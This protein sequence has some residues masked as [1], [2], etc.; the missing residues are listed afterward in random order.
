MCGIA[1]IVSGI[2]IDLSPSTLF[3]SPNPEPL[4]TVSV[5]DL[6]AALRRRGPDSLGSKKVILQYNKNLNSVEDRELVCEVIEDAEIENDQSY[7]QNCS[8]G[9]AGNYN[10]LGNI[11]ELQFIGATL[12]LRG[13]NPIIQPFVDSYGNVLIYNGEIFG[14][15]HVESDRNDGEVLMQT[16]ANCCSCGS[17]GHTGPCSVAG[18]GCNSVPNVFSTIKGPWAI[19][20][21]Q[22]SS[23]TLWFGRD[24]FGRR[25]LVVHWPTVK[26]S[27]FLL[28][29]VSPFSSVYQS[30]DF[31][32]ENGTH[33]NFWEELSCGIY[34]LSMDASKL[35][36]YLAGEVKKH[37]WGNAMLSELIKWERVSF[38]PKPD[39]LH[40]SLNE[41]LEGQRHRH[42]ASSDIV[43][44]ESGPDQTMVSLPAHNVLSALR[45]S[46]ILRASQYRIFE[47][48]RCYSRQEEHV[49]VAVLFSG[50]LDSMIL[51]ALLD[52]CLDPSYGIDLLN[53]S[54]D[55]QSAPDRISAKAGVKEL[56]RIAPLRRWKLVE[57]DSD[58]SKL[59]LEMK[60]V[61]SLINPANTYMDLNI[62]VALW[63]AASGDG[64]VSE[65][66]GNNSD[67]DQQ[68]LRYKSE[69]R[70]V[71]V[72]SG[73]DEQCAG[74]GRHRTKYR[75][76][77]WHGLNEEMKLDVQRIWKRNMGRD[78]RC[79][80]DNGKEAR[81]PFLD[82][83]VIKVL[84]DIPLWEVTN[85]DQPSGTGDKKIL[86]EVA[87]MLGLHEAA[88]LP[89]RAI[90]FG[91]RIARESNRNVF[92][93]N[94]AANQASAGSVVI[95]RS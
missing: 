52:E 35:H 61:M 67:E 17:N 60:H 25:S 5:D 4:V 23:R 73:A 2:R 85:L 77:G 37:E 87:R 86:R 9:K 66:P 24:A 19:I 59:T 41:T 14:G 21:W 15:I 95:N 63:L 11:G 78:D 80:A 68:R 16:L 70:I 22:E 71:L 76:G 72:G 39:E 33:H 54:F 83:D 1:L 93:S 10:Q 55:G 65:R 40:G 81:F 50:G 36:G 31:E 13:L 49:P 53:V 29:S 92:G 75:C 62:G 46:V 47:A 44:F 8:N 34:S 6:K 69:A 84:L 26:D 28:S 88:V 58:L 51:S 82:E 94:R 56:R 89:K 57:I 43:T 64:W 42:P 79:I 18:H 45:K 90:Q 38:N 20:Y 3:Q 7:L 48:V 32:V 91:S 27:R 74:Y 30:S 12:Q